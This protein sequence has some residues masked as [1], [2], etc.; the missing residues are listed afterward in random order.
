MTSKSAGARSFVALAFDMQFVFAGR[1]GGS[2]AFLEALK[3]VCVLARSFDGVVGFAKAGRAVSFNC[4]NTHI[5][6]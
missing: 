2:A 3:A 1:C 5:E 6:S 4:D